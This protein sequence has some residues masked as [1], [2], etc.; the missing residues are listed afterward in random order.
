M[1][2]FHMA[3][4]RWYYSNMLPFICIRLSHEEETANLSH[5]VVLVGS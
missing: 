3:E 2:L 1:L 4:V 5:H